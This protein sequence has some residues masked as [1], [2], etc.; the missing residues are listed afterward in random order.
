MC[1]SIHALRCAM[2]CSTARF[3]PS[4]S[5]SNAARFLLIDLPPS[6]ALAKNVRDEAPIPPPERSL[7]VDRAH[8]RAALEVV[9]IADIEQLR[10]LAHFV[11][12]GGS[13]GHPRHQ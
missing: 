7:L 10:V 8:A 3:S 5:S 9:V 11:P 1:A 13:P 6:A 4:S 12:F 2:A